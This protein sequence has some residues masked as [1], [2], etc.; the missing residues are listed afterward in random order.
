MLSVWALSLMVKSHENRMAVSLGCIQDVWPLAIAWH[1]VVPELWTIW[2][3][4]LS[5]CQWVYMGDC[6]VCWCASFK[7]FVINGLRWLHYYMIWSTEEGVPW[8]H[9]FTSRCL[10]SERL[11]LGWSRVSPFQAW[12]FSFQNKMVTLCFI[13]PPQSA[14]KCITV[15]VVW[16]QML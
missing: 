16:L 2:L 7:E 11:Q 1:W 5:S 8:C 3:Q 12:S 14:Q 9:S 15:S 4:T 13:A 10:W 6:S